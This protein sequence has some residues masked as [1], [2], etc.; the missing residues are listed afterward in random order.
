MSLVDIDNNP[1]LHGFGITIRTLD[2]TIADLQLHR[3]W[4]AS[5]QVSSV[6][7]TSPESV[8]WER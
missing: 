2:A 4:N 5:G 3:G 7:N 1:L 8:I 6:G